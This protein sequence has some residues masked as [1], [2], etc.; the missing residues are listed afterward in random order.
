MKIFHLKNT[1]F[2]L[3]FSIRRIKQ[4]AF[5]R[6]SFTDASKYQLDSINQ[7]DWNKLL[8]VKLNYWKPTEN[9]SMIGW[10]YNNVNDIFELCFY[11]HKDSV[12]GNTGVFEV[13][14]DEEFIVEIVRKKNDIILNI[15]TATMAQS[16]TV[17]FKYIKKLWEIT[18]W[19]GGN[20]AAPK[21]ITFYKTRL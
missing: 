21:L 1:H 8:G 11:W 7:Q 19:F 17:R 6:C 9:S 14:T 4:Y 5:W 12:Q 10:R 18:S 16:N 20:K 13:Q 15:T 2:Q 3:P